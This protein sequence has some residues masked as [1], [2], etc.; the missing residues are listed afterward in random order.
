MRIQ[1][2]V[3]TTTQAQGPDSRSCEVSYSD[4]PRPKSQG[5]DQLEKKYRQCGGQ[6]KKRELGLPL[7]GFADVGFCAP[8]KIS[9]VVNPGFALGNLDFYA[10][11]FGDRIKSLFELT[12]EF[13]EKGE[14]V[15]T[16][17]LSA[18]GLVTPSAMD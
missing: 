18:Y 14:G 6:L 3:A 7:H 13:N 1:K 5:I 15:A 11:E 2:A 17:P 16:V 9:M 8:R 4:I 12:F 10:P